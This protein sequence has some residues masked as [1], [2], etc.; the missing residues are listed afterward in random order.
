MASRLRPVSPL[1]VVGHR[2]D[3]GDRRLRG[4]AR[5][6]RGG[7]VD[8]VDARI[9]CRQVGS[10]LPAAR[11]VRVQVHRLGKPLT[12]S[13]DER[14]RGWRSQ[15]ARH[16]L[17][18]QDVRPCF[19][20]LLGDAQVVV[21]RVEALVGTGEVARVADGALGDRTCSDHGFDSRLHLLD[22]IE[23]IE[24]PEDIHPAC[25]GLSDEL[26]RHCVGI[27]RVA[28]RVASPQQHLRADVGS[29]RSDA[30]QPFPGI[31]VQESERDVEGG[32]A[33]A[34]QAEQLRH[35]VGHLAS[36]GHEVDRAQPRGQNRLVG[37]AQRGVGDSNGRRSP[38]FGGEAC[39]SQLGEALAGAF[40]RQ[41]GG[42]P[43]LRGWIDAGGRRAVRLVHR[44]VSQ[45]TQEPGGPVGT[46]RRRPSARVG[47]R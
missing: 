8:G 21:E 20:E 36:S 4:H 39:W 40:G 25:G 45:E 33:P 18:A 6:R 37:V 42:R 2:H 29:C 19:V 17:D 3:R 38:Q 22:G 28:H 44:H 35:V 16:V 11:V 27:R 24:H 15:Q 13:A 10:E 7:A 26:V 34:L 12:Q 32:T 46:H 5:Q 41:A 1:G 47:R 14:R 31:L 30:S 23:R 9:D 43:Q